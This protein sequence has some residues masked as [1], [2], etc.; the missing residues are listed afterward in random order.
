MATNNFL[1]T[2]AKNY[3]TILDLEYID[4]EYI[5]DDTK[6]NIVNELK[7]INKNE[8]SVD[9]LNVIDER[10]KNN[11]FQGKYFFELYFKNSKQ[12]TRGDTITIKICY[13]SGYYNGLNFDFDFFRDG[14]EEDLEY[15]LNDFLEEEKKDF[16]HH[17]ENIEKVLLKNSTGYKKTRQASNGECGYE[18]L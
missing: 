15:I 5:L 16:L 7:A 14:Q 9:Y 1:K 12:D 4:N 13:R 3:Y 8:N 17:I 18:K 2:N 11:N 6:E 10:T